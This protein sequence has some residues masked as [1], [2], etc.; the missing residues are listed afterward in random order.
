MAVIKNPEENFKSALADWSLNPKISI[1]DPELTLTVPPH[2]TASTGF[3]AFSHSFEPFINR[4]ASDFID[5]YAL[6]SLKKIIRYLPIA[7]KDGL[8]REAREALSFTAT[9]GGLCIANIGTTLPHGIG[10]AMGG[11][12]PDMVHGESLAIVYP[13]INRWTWK[14]A[15]E[16]YAVVARLFNPELES[17]PDEIAAEK[18][19]DEIDS[20]LKEIGLW[21]SLKDKDVPE[22]KLEDIIQDVFKL[23]NY[24]LHPKVASL[25]DVNDLL[26][27]SYS[28]KG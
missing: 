24:T 7:T 3:D 1:V 11:Q 10:M 12:I 20:F 21:M 2:I 23:R 22:N 9:L 8:N 15:I 5:L 16:K 13:E 19:C 18:C 28:R 4:Y 14:Q 25:E 26:K 17:E 27:R 6:D